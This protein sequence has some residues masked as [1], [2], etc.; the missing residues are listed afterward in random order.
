MQ[1]NW[2]FPGRIINISVPPGS[3]EPRCPA[4]QHPGRGVFPGNENGNE[5]WLAPAQF[6]LPE[7]PVLGFLLTWAHLVFSTTI[8]RGHYS[9]PIL[10]TEM[11]GFR[12]NLCDEAEWGW[13]SAFGG[14]IAEVK[15]LQE[16]QKTKWGWWH[17][18]VCKRSLNLSGQQN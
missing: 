4:L 18:T 2:L 12:G 6:W 16:T 14:G 15:G 10:K 17:Q 3:G 11:W 8:N 9:T 13:K 5:E 1:V 7:G